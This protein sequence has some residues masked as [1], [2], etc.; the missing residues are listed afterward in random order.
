MTGLLRHAS[1]LSWGIVDIVP[2]LAVS[3]FAGGVERLAGED[4]A[5]LRVAGDGPAVVA[6]R[7]GHASRVALAGIEDP[8]SAGDAV[9]RGAAAARRGRA[10]IR[11]AVR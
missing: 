11:R 1:H 6:E 2:R 3:V 9:P 7:F 5:G 8:A 10:G 4:L